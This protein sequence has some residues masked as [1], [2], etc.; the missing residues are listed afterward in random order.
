MNE[1]QRSIL[2]ERLLANREIT[3]TGCW[4][5]TKSCRP[6][7]YGQTS[8]PGT[9]LNRGVHRV[10]AALWL[11]FALDSELLIIHSCDTPR[12]FNPEHLRPATS[13]DNTADMMSKRRNGFKAHAG[14][15]NG[16]AKVTPEQVREIRSRREGGETYAALGTAF[17][18]TPQ[19]AFA[20][21]SRK[22]WSHV[23]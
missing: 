14:E 12:C 16:Y 22:N 19:G 6:K 21:C 2:A 11:G 3:P 20:I 18:M 10:A 7:G 17:G 9:G 1:G 8:I 23:V 5:W 13:A 15:E 4:L